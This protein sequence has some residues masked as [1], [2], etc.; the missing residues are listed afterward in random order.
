MKH[1]LNGSWNVKRLSDGLHFKGSVPGSVMND[2]LE[3]G[4][5]EDPFFRD[6]EYKAYELFRHDYEYS[7]VFSIDKKTFKQNRISL[8]C[9]GID[10]LSNIYINDRFLAKTDNMHRTY[11][12]DIKSYLKAG[13]NII[14]IVLESPV[15]YIEKAWKERGPVWGVCAKDGYQFIRKAHYMFGWDWGPAIPDCGIWRNIYI[16]SY[17]IASIMGVNIRQT[18]KDGSVML[19]FESIISI[20]DFKDLDIRYIVYE[21]DESKIYLAS[22]FQKP[23]TIEINDPKLW[24]PAGYGEQDLYR[25]SV[26]LLSGNDV[27]DKKEMKIGLRTLTVRREDDQWGQSFTYN[28][29]GIDI[30]A[31]GANYIPEDNIL[32]RCSEQRTRDLLTQA[33][34]ANFNSI[35]V[36]GGG[37]YP[38]DYFYDIC[39]ELGLMVWQDFMF[40]CA[41]Y[42]LDDKDFVESIKCEMRD[43]MRRLRHHASLALWCGNNEMEWLWMDTQTEGRSREQMD[44]YLELFEGIMPPVAREEDPDRL[45]W[46]AS[47]SSGGNFDA[48]NDENRGDVHYWDVW[49]GLKPFTEYR[50]FF[51]RFCS[52]F[53]FQSFPCLRTVETYTLPE[54]RN[55]FSYVMESHQKNGGANG[56]ILYYLSENFR[57]PKDFESLLYVSQLLQ[58]E[59]IKYGVEHWRRNR[60]RCMGSI[61]WQ[62]ND[63]WPV[64]SWSS[65]DSF[66][67]WKALH[68][69]AKRF[70]SPVMASAED[71]GMAVDIHVSNESRF[72][73]EGTLKWK[74]MDRDGT[75]HE[76]GEIETTVGMLSSKKVISLD[77]SKLLEGMDVRRRTFLWFEYTD[78]AGNE[79]GSV[80]LFVP[81]KYF[82]YT[83]PDISIAMRQSEEGIKLDLLAKSFASYV[84]IDMEDQDAVFSDNFFSLVP[85]IIKTISVDT[86]N[87]KPSGTGRYLPEDFRVMSIFN[88]Y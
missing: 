26:H 78:S 74:L 77:F 12:F 31:K 32:A 61:Y 88:S 19:K 80:L 79:S 39:D 5:T 28:I 56:K 38:Y 43:N 17:S 46:P 87:L 33:A 85:G 42:R 23:A 69:F 68:Y 16:E 76:T 27:I 70:Y 30:F 1:D 10:T 29:N 35:R 44:E 13:K 67:R 55:I 7:R 45:Y 49:H 83:K 14:R 50:K 64:A 41:Q 71:K 47:P 48:P 20:S 3:N 9:E 75:V 34:K 58:A 57:N 37:I 22:G 52:E 18:H 8:V 36:W 82:E 54:D 72:D 63:C 40:A 2:L 25:V 11:R 62:F 84:Y 15:E 66:H 51:F 86:K 24:W 81:N 73:S 4:L 59:A 21:P 53:G 65:I 6:N 60:G